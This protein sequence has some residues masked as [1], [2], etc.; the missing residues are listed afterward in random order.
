MSVPGRKILFALN[1]VIPLVCGLIIYVT[2]AENT[3]VSDVFRALR[4]VIEPVKYPLI[5]RNY[6]CD[7]LWAYSLFFCIRITLGDNLKG[8]HGITVIAVTVVVSMVLEFLQLAKAFHGTFDWLDIVAELSA[9]AVA[10]IISTIIER[11]SK[12]ET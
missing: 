10:L 1:M 4:T 2:K 11:R 12:N 7:F 5:I 9:I 3:F 8:K 6:A